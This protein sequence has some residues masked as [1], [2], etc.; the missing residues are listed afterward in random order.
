MKWC[1]VVTVLGLL[2][3]SFGVCGCGTKEPPAGQSKDSQTESPLTKPLAEK[4]APDP[5]NFQ[6]AQVKGQ[7]KLQLPKLGRWLV[8]AQD[9]AGNKWEAA[10]VFTRN[11]DGRTNSG[12]FDWKSRLASGREH[13]QGTFDAESRMIRWTGN[14]VENPVG[15]I[16]HAN[17]EAEV[18][19]DC[20][21]LINGKW[22][23]N[24]SVPGTWTA[25]WKAAEGDE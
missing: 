10:L 18:S 25:E 8:K 4:L 6:P 1:H 23:G 3:L 2:C 24:G 17:Y 5:V 20:L 12:Y 9:V 13:F 11:I 16:I 15:S 7:E 19:A 22:S 21:R 14:R